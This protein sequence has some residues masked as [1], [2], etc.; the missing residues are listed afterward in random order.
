MIS[1]LKR[2]L[3][4]RLRT[5]FAKS[6]EDIQLWQILGGPRR[7]VYADI[8]SHHPIRGS[9]S[10][11]FYLRG[12]RGVCVDP[13]PELPPLYRRLRPGDIFLN[14]GVA[15]RP[16]QLDYY[17]FGESRSNL[18]TLSEEQVSFLNLPVVGSIPVAVTTLANL[19]KHVF[20]GDSSIDFLSVDCEGMDEAVLRGNDWDIYRPLIV[21][22]ETGRPLSENLTS[23]LGR[24]MY[25]KGYELIGKSVLGP[26]APGVGSL[27]FSR[28]DRTG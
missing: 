14:E 5:S 17:Q 25:S 22:V 13:N 1:R 3:Y 9:N 24:F 6:G 21:C 8:G 11:F 26:R 19:F 20:G 7:G 4:R 2:Y 23:P 10:F 15:D 16:G 18:N 12:W 27:F 28:E